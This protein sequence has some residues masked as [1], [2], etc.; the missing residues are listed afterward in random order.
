VDNILGRLSLFEFVGVLIPGAVAV[1][2]SYW[3]FASMPHDV[4]ASA[5][6]AL[7]LV[8]YVAGHLMQALLRVPFADK[9][10][11]PRVEPRTT[12][13]VDA[14]DKRYSHAFLELLVKKASARGWP[15]PA[16]EPGRVIALARAELRAK[17]LDARAETMLA[18]HFLALGLAVACCVVAFSCLLALID[19]FRWSRLG[20]AGGAVAAAWLFRRRADDYDRYYADHVWADFAALPDSVESSAGTNVGAAR[21]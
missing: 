15:D 5:V 21:S 16:T 12:R 3:A 7:L 9:L 20:V 18:M 8:F 13:L 6:L 10:V 14:G 1:G 4:G 2:G 11:G 19:D 17:K